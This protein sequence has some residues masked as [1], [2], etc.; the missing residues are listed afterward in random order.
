[1]QGFG[2]VESLLFFRVSGEESIKTG[3]LW[4]FFYLPGFCSVLGMQQR[5]AKK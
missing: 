3:L 1:M 2:T 4:M 5:S